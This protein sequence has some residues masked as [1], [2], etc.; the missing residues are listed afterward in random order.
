MILLAG[1]QGLVRGAVGLA[2]ALGVSPLVIG[3]TVVSFGTSSPELAV[4]IRSALGGADDVAVANAVGSNIA[5]VLFI[6]GVAAV[7][8]PIPIAPRLA[9]IVTP[10]MVACSLALFGCSLDRRISR[11]EAAG[12]VAGLAGY[13]WLSYRMSRSR[14]DDDESVM[15]PPPEDRRYALNG[16]L[17]VVGLAM[18]VFGSDM[19]VK[20]AVSI[21]GAAGM[22]EA[23]IGL[24]IVAIGTSLPELATTVVAV[25]RNEPDIAAGNVVGSNIFNILAIVGLTGLVKPLTMSNALV[26]RDMPVMIVAAVILVPW[27]L[28]RRKLSR[29]EGAVL[30]VAYVVYLGWLVMTGG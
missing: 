12:L 5:N 10:L 15:I 21:A 27:F 22:S 30:L 23:V 6:L 19:M 29:I 17:C 4:C 25:Q 18:L 9:T 28:T 2:R 13:L 20:A 16:V 24:T 7:L 1:G 26:F 11:L 3:L 8:R 14:Q